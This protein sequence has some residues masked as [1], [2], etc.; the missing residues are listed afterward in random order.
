MTRCSITII[1]LSKESFSPTLILCLDFL[2][3]RH[4]LIYIVMTALLTATV[5]RS[6]KKKKRITPF[7]L[8]PLHSFFKPVIGS[9]WKINLLQ[10]K[11]V[12]TGGWQE[13]EHVPPLIPII[14]VSDAKENKNKASSK[15]WLWL[16]VRRR[17]SMYWVLLHTL[18]INHFVVKPP[19][20]H[21]TF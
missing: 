16:S 7:H 3:W 18:S 6:K 8:Y 19:P 1:M 10:A 12:G 14:T 20:N 15:W 9:K 11:E 21:L 17:V 2:S 5:P 4:W 13:G